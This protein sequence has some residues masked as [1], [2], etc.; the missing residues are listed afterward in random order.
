[1]IRWCVALALACTACA[2]GPRAKGHQDAATGGVATAA[3]STMD[4][5]AMEPVTAAPW[6]AFA[7]LEPFSEPLLPPF[8]EPE[9]RQW[10]VDPR[11]AGVDEG[12]ATEVT[13]VTDGEHF[14]VP[15]ATMM[16]HQYAKVSPWN[17]DDDAIFSAI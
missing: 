2:G 11:T 16:V 1:M 8:V 17:A 12:A 13:R 9:Y 7:P 15:A 3:A 5:P 6:P 10:R 4:T 14:G